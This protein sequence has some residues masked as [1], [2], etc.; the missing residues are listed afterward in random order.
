MNNSEMRAVG[1]KQQK[2]PNLPLRAP[3]GAG[4]WGSHVGGKPP[5]YSWEFGRDG[6]RSA[7]PGL[8]VF[9]TLSGAETQLVSHWL[10]VDL[11][12]R[13][14]SR[15]QRDSCRMGKD[16]A[17]KGAAFH[18][19]LKRNHVILCSWKLLFVLNKPKARVSRSTVL[20]GLH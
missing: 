9:S 12:V 10:S 17:L 20:W 6:S 3:P 18:T 5:R 8:V 14:A 16:V 4:W 1:A 13:Q 7:T 2:L 11:G 15:C 19:H